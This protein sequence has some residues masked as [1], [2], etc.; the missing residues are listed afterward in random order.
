MGLSSSS[1][2]AASPVVKIRNNDSI[3]YISNNSY[4][5]IIVIV[6]AAGHGTILGVDD[7][8]VNDQEDSL[9]SNDVDD[10]GRW[11]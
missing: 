9:A 4:V 1:P 5:W 6:S 7:D 2:I 8:D 10:G 3:R 11:F